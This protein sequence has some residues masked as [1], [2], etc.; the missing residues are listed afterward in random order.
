MRRFEVPQDVHTLPPEK[1]DYHMKKFLKY[2]KHKTKFKHPLGYKL[3]SAGKP[4]SPIKDETTGIKEGYAGI[5]LDLNG[6][7]GKRKTIE[8]IEIPRAFSPVDTIASAP[9]PT[10]SPS[11]S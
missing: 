9:T 11:K 3:T 4:V 8:S 6:K 7:K 10:L 2:Q 1:L 5:I